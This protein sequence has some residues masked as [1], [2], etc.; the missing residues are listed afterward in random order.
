MILW[1]S[2]V[3]VLKVLQNI[4]INKIYAFILKKLFFML[5]CMYIF[6]EMKF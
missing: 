1:K 5:L 2:F 4:L 6:N 3:Y